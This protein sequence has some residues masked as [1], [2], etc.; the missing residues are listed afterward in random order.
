M[1]HIRLLLVLAFGLVAVFGLIQGP[2]AE[3]AGADR[4]DWPTEASTVSGRV[5]VRGTALSDGPSFRSYRLEFGSGREPSAWRAIGPERDHTVENGVLGIWDTGDL[6]TGEYT[7]RLTVFDEGG[8][9][10]QSWVRVIVA[11]PS[12]TP[13]P[14]RVGP[15]P[16]SIVTVTPEPEPIATPTAEATST[17]EPGAQPTDEH[18]ADAHA[19]EEVVA[20]PAPP[21]RDPPPMTGGP[22]RCPMLYYHEVPGQAGLAAQ[23]T[24]YLQAGYR[25]VPMGRLV[26][27]LEGRAAAP[28]GCL[29]LTFDDGLASQM[30]G[31]L[32]VLL[33]FRL[34]ATFFVMPGFRDGAH[35]Y[36]T[37]DHYRA[38]RQ[39]G[40]E[41]GS[42]TLNHAS[43]PS[44]RRINFGAFLSEL[45]DS[46]AYLEEEVGDTVDLLA[47]PNGAWDPATA[48]EVRKAGYRAAA[49]TMR[50][51][52]QRPEDLF[53]LRRIRVDPW[54]APG[55]VL[56]RLRG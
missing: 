11:A 35:R 49:S 53:W 1:V 12:A 55:A 41:I 36:M 29:V 26:D 21:A 18:E 2:L 8:G 9:E 28:P 7:L 6:P 31:A 43:L 14:G 45:V 24:S 39:A 40:M 19:E 23:I 47:Y 27:G 34:S 3:A 5:E 25:P 33:R 15:T 13:T 51:G 44:L 46:K 54:E 17:D 42:H 16:T 38:L 32:P 22:F 4:I 48:E 37:P 52:W 30:T 50:G 56:A 20:R 10:T